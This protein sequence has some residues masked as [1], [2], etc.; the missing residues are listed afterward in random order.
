MRFI[1]PWLLWA[2]G[3]NPGMGFYHQFTG[4]NFSKSS[5]FDATPLFFIHDLRA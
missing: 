3:L 2:I 1:F 5:Y 4:K